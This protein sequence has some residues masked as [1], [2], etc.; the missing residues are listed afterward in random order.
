MPATHAINVSLYA[1]PLYDAVNDFEPVS[2]I[3]TGP[4]ML[5]VNPA[6]PASSV[7][8]LIAFAKARPAHLSSETQPSDICRIPARPAP[9]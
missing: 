8:D 7:K 5:V 9:R 2:L 1:K 6:V 3:A 4:Y